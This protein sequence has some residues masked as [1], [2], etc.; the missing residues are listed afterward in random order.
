[1]LAHNDYETFQMLNKDEGGIQNKANRLNRDEIELYKHVVGRSIGTAINYYRA[2]DE[3]QRTMQ[4]L[5]CTI[6]HVFNFELSCCFYCLTNYRNSL[7]LTYFE[8]L[9]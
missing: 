2:G 5:P 1:M 4:S 7:N 8:T 9:F 3:T 6:F